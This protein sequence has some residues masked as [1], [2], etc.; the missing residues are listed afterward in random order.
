MSEK[1]LSQ[2]G[3]HSK[4]H[5]VEGERLRTVKDRP[6]NSSFDKLVIKA[7]FDKLLGTSTNV[8]GS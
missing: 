3:Y 2:E 1:A 8:I 7:Q 4:R 5:A 6:I